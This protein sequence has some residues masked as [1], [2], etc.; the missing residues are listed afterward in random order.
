MCFY[1]GRSFIESKKLSVSGLRKV[2][3]TLCSVT[4]WL[5]GRKEEA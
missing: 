2:T 4:K 1:E 5:V 3:T